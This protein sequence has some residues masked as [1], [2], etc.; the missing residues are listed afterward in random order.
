MLRAPPGLRALPPARGNTVIHCVSLRVSVSGEFY[1]I[2]GWSHA[3]MFMRFPSAPRE[4]ETPKSIRTSRAFLFSTSTFSLYFISRIYIFP[5][6]S[7]QRALSPFIFR[8]NRISVDPRDRKG[9]NA[10]RC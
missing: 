6:F 10:R 4:K 2:E 1:S 5:S 3:V 8:S 9:E 7:R